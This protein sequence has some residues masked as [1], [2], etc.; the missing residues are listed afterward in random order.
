MEHNENNMTEKLI[1]ITSMLWCI[2]N[3][4]FISFDYLNR[5]FGVPPHGDV[6]MLSDY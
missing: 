4:D 1:Q 5:I 2:G 3:I 6:R